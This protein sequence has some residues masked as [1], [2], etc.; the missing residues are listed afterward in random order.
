MK[1]GKGRY[2]ECVCRN[3]RGND[4]EREGAKGVRC[5]ERV[6]RGTLNSGTRRQSWGLK[7]CSNLRGEDGQG[8]K[9]KG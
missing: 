1:E 2:L 3:P 8:E 7:T 6:I 5:A 4:P 9:P